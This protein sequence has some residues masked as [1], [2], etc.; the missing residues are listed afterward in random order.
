MFG[1]VSP[2]GLVTAAAYFYVALMAGRASRK[3]GHGWGRVAV[4]AATWPV[5]LWK[6]IEDLYRVKAD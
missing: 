3:A 4:D 2:L 1:L 5:M 6:T